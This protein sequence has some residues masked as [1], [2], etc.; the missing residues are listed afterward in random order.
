MSHSVTRLLLAL[1]RRV[2]ARRTLRYA[3]ASPTWLHLVSH[4]ISSSRLTACYSTVSSRK[5]AKNKITSNDITSTP[6]IP[7]GN[8]R[9]MEHERPL[10]PWP[11]SGVI[12][13][14]SHSVHPLIERSMFRI[15]SSVK[16]AII[17][18]LYHHLFMFTF[19][20]QLSLALSPP[21]GGS[22][23]VEVSHFHSLFVFSTLFLRSLNSSFFLSLPSFHSV[24]HAHA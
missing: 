24:Q 13:G 23:T 14:H 11:S 5:Y 10:R 2:K 3:D 4:A 17:E 6:C 18:P 20:L 1:L 7:E 15:C 12:N 9:A 19:E 8:L 22:F 21:S 16:A